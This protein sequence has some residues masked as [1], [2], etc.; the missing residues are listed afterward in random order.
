MPEYVIHIGPPKAGSKYL[1]TSMASLS[2][3]MLKSGISYPTHLFTP[4]R[5]LAHHHLV[6]QI[7]EGPSARLE[8]EFAALNASGV[9]LVVLSCEGFFGLSDEKLHYLMRLMDASAVHVVYYC[10]R[11]SERLPSLWKQDVKM[12]RTETLPEKYARTVINPVK[13]P[14]L[15]P[16]LV[17]DRFA[18]V[19]GRDSINIVSFNNLVENKVDLVDHFFETFL[20]WVAP[21]K[22]TQVMSNESPDGFD[23]EIIRVLNV[24]HFRDTEETTDRIRINY[25]QMKDHLDLQA[26]KEAM[27][28]DMTTLLLDD[29]GVMFSNIPVELD[30]YKDR[31][32][33]QRYGKM[34]F[35]PKATR[36][37]YVR[38]S[39]LLE[40]HIASRLKDIYA[41]VVSHKK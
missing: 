29:N 6:E 39:Y 37:P 38:Q 40:D 23:T 26:I 18:D 11:W 19:F 25:T 10:R 32:V 9:R 12:G 41:A 30:R 5:R 2:D 33:S 3:E 34:F 20:K 21:F 7:Q 28:N 22:P 15:N 13:A 14:D 31:L 24:L 17:W 8:E 36:F 4:S 1:Q 35:R 16:S 27:Q